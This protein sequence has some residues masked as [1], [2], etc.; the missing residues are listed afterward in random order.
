MNTWS[1][2]SEKDLW[3]EP[4]DWSGT[5]YSV[6]L[7]DGREREVRTY[8]DEC[9]DGTI[10]THC[11]YTY[12]D[13][14]ANLDDVLMWRRIEKPDCG[15]TAGKPKETA[16]DAVEKAA[17]EYSCTNPSE[18]TNGL[19]D[20]SELEWAFEAGAEWERNQEREAMRMGMEEAIQRI[21]T[22][23]SNT[24]LLTFERGFRK[25]AEWQE[26]QDSICSEE[27]FEDGCKWQK[28]Q[29]MK[30]A[31]PA[32]VSFGQ[33]VMQE[34]PISTSVAKDGDKVKVIIVKEDKENEIL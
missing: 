1:I 31:I 24:A 3:N 5:Y 8:A 7:K 29:M 11:E 4:V 16:S 6:I 17:I 18:R 28:E 19:Y 10:T 9:G 30:D 26:R 33:V 13:S 23:T 14:G 12:D 32:R 25:G 22:L 15:A 27:V 20:K 21:M 2:Q 34:R